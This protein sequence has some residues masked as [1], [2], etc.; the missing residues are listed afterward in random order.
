MAI[1]RKMS[2]SVY[3]IV[4]QRLNDMVK[5]TLPES[6]S[7]GVD[8]IPIGSTP[9]TRCRRQAR[10]KVSSALRSSRRT[11]RSERI[12]GDERGAYVVLLRF[13]VT[14][15]GMAYGARALGSRSRHSSRG[16]D[17]PPGSAGKP[18]AGQRAAGNRM[19]RNR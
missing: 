6:Q 11:M 13:S 9:V 3:G 4:L 15:H 18:C 7:P 5:A 10:I 19:F 2:E 17:V 14:E 1:K 16:S 12:Q 8:L